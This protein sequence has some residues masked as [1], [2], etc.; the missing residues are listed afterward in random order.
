[1]ESRDYIAIVAAAIS[2]GGA[3]TSGYIASRGQRRQ[4]FAEL[5]KWADE[6][7]DVL[8]RAVYACD[9]DP[10]R[11]ENNG[12]FNLR[13]DLRTSLSSLLDRGRWFFPN[14]HHEEVNVDTDEAFRGLR[15]RALSAIAKAYELVG[16]MNY[17]A[18]EP[19]LR[20]RKELVAMKRQFVSEVQA[21]LDPR[22]RRAEFSRLTSFAGAATGQDVRIEADP[23]SRRLEAR[24]GGE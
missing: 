20:L 13:H 18:H 24:G 23:A 16:K 21:Y 10:Q 15:Q 5:R 1:M 6:V 3:V 9:I 11:V 19:N 17:K 12:F 4:Y 2:L 14:L 8:S 22:K 7:C